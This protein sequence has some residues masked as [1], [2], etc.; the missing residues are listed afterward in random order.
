MVFAAA[1]WCGWCGGH[2]AIAATPAQGA[3]TIVH[4][5]DYVSVDYP[6]F[7]RDGKVTN[8]SE[9]DEQKEFVTQSVA[10]LEQLP[11]RPDTPG[12]LD[13]ARALLARVDAKAPGPEVAALAAGLRADVIRIY[14]LAV[15]P[16]QAPDIARASALYAAQ[17]S[18]CHGAAGRADGPLAKGMEP[19][20]RNF[21]DEAKM[22][23]RSTY[24]LYNTISLGVA[25]TTMR[26]F[27]EL[28]DADRWGLALVVSN[29]RRP[30]D[31]IAKGEALWK[32]GKGK[33]ELANLAQLVNLT[34]AVAAE[35]GGDDLVGRF[36]DDLNFHRHGLTV[37]GP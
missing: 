36:A 27:P 17:C 34:P 16:K 30:P 25:G 31:L 28:S 6:E 2:A 23:V 7:V 3:Q 22:A 5:L 24:G 1:L 37:N 13:K 12:L 14:D 19:P 8:Q 20:P 10:L 21:H 4:M 29:L 18:A 26:A 35:K 33:T 11:P 32:A 9:Y 15:A